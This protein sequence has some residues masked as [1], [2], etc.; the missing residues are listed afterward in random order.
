MTEQ[1]W[2]TFPDGREICHLTAAGKREYRNRTLKMRK[3][4]GE[5]CRWCGEWMRE[6]ETTFDH[7]AR[8]NGRQDDRAEI[9]DPETGKVRWLNAAVHK[10]CNGM[11]GSRPQ[12]TRSE[13]TSQR[14]ES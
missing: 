5:L 14:A 1:P 2:V 7:D 10:L 4:Q 12:L 8:R 9:K 11:R 13:V 6:E 3:R